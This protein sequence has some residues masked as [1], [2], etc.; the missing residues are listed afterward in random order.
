MQKVLLHLP[1]ARP[2]NDKIHGSGPRV[3]GRKPVGLA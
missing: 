1:S 2:T 3:D